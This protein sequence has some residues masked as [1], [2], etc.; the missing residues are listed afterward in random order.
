M[1]LLPSLGPR[2]RFRPDAQIKLFYRNAFVG[3]NV[4]NTT[5][6]RQRV[7][8]LAPNGVWTPFDLRFQND[9]NV[10]DRFLV[11]GPGNY[12]GWR[13]RYQFPNC[14]SAQIVRGTCVTPV[15][16]PGGSVV[17]SVEVMPS[18]SRTSPRALGVRLQV[19]S[20]GNYRGTDVVGFTVERF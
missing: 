8:D 15:V 12:R 19:V 9:G 3:N 16:P 20:T 11:L 4:Y 7:D 17:G 6:A 5:G 1:L 14:A 18:G 13:F 2:A 10:E